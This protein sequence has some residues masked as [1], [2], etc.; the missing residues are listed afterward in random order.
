M[1]W[2]PKKME[3][4]INFERNITFPNTFVAIILHWFM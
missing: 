1:G 3:T 2:E 4:V